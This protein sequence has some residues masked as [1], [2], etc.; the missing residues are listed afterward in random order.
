MMDVGVQRGNWRRSPGVAALVAAAGLAIEYAGLRLKN[1]PGRTL[2]VLGAIAVTASFALTGHTTDGAVWPP[3]RLLLALHVTIVAYWLGSVVA[4]T[5]LTQVATT[6]ALYRISTAFSVSAVWIV[7]VILPL[8]VGVAVGLLP[9][10][11]ALRTVYGGFLA[12]K[13]TG[14]VVLLALAA[15]NRW[16]MVPALQREP[17]EATQRFRRMLHAEYLLLIGVVSVTAVMTSLYSWH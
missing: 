13:V 5:R 6:P 4:L 8:G 1:A 12:A 17:L 16:R 11:A 14:F 7:P 3:V 10:L 9:N 2:S 15:A